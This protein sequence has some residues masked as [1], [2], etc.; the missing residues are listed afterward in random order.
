MKQ[1]YMLK[2][3]DGP[4][5]ARPYILSDYSTINKREFDYLRSKGFGILG[6]AIL[7]PL[8]DMRKKSLLEKI[9]SEI[10]PGDCIISSSKNLNAWDEKEFILIELSRQR[11]SPRYEEEVCGSV[12]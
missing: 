5:S 8:V 2:M 12:V 11:F 9:K 4:M 1:Y 7:T 10:K 3:G 6:D